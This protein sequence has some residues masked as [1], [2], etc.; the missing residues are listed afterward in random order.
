MLLSLLKI[1]V[2]FLLLLLLSYGLLALLGAIIAVNKKF[3]PASTGIELYLSTNGMHTDFIL[4]LQNELFDWTKYIDVQKFAL[5][6]NQII[7]LGIGWGD[8]AV[9]L[10]IAEWSELTLKMGLSTL[11]LPTPTILH[12]TAYDQFPTEHLKIRKTKITKAQYLQ[13]CQFILSYFAVDT[14]QQKQFIE[15][16]GYTL[17]DIFYHAN[18]Q[19][20]AFYTCNTWVNHGLRTIGVRTA[21]WTPLDKGI[22]YQFEKI[23]S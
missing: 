23:I 11:L 9:H 6:T 21:L 1:L 5:N 8:K 10:D 20:H 7:G 19:Y 3:R 4:P 13:L 22:F 14:Q 16:G 15:G 2:V 12:L 17:N 18:G